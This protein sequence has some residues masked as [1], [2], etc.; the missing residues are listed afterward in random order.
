MSP[1]LIGETVVSTAVV[2]RLHWLRF[3]NGELLRC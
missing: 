2:A 1:C 3:P